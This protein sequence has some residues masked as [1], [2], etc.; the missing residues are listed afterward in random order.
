MPYL[1]TLKMPYC[2]DTNAINRNKMIQDYFISVCVSLYDSPENRIKCAYWMTRSRRAVA[3][4][5]SGSIFPHSS[6][7]RFDVMMIECFS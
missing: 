6:K 5:G 4:A 3:S 1:A 2:I 7:S